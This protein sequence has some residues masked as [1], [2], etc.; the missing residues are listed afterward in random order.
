MHS[1]DQLSPTARE[2]VRLLFLSKQH[3]APAD[4]LA[5]RTYYPDAEVQTALTE[6]ERDGIVNRDQTGCYVL[7]APMVTQLLPKQQ[8]ADALLWEGLALAQQVMN[9]MAN[10]TVSPDAAEAQFRARMKQLMRDL[11]REDE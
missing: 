6:L 4:D 1:Y 7:A 8:R 11:D 10:E 2:V 9:A 3:T 5:G